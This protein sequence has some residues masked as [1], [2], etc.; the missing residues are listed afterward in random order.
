M[1]LSNKKER[2]RFFR[3]AF[4]G[5]IGAIIDFGILN[6]LN[7][8][9]R[10]PILAAQAFSFST[11]VISNFTWNRLWTYPESRNKPIGKQLLQ[12]VIV[13]V[14]GL[15]IRTLIFSGLDSLMINLSEHV[16]PT[17]FILNPDIIGHNS[18]LAIVIIIILFW[19]F[20]VNRFWTYN[21]IR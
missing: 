1:I 11:A 2:S 6:L 21:D 15:A 17:N 19:N 7:Q 4:V 18:S 14:M 10:I 8:V 5:I 3:F 16:F 9:F 20:F 12:F 13:S